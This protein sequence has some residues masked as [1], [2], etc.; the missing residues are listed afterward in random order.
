MNK[1]LF[2][3]LLLVIAIFVVALYYSLSKPIK[4]GL[5]L[6]G[7]AYVV[8]EAVKDQNKNVKIDNDAMNRL[9]EVLNR[10]VNGIGVAESTIQ[11]AGDNRVIIELP[12]LQNTEDA[13]KLIGKTALMEF[14]LMN[15]DGSL[16]ETLLTG[17]ALKKA[18]V[19]YDNLGRPQI[20]FEMTPEGA[21]T[22]A[23]MIGADE[24]FVQCF[25]RMGTENFQYDVNIEGVIKQD[26]DKSLKEGVLLQAL[27]SSKEGPVV[28]VIDE[29][30]KA[31]P[32][33]DSFLLDF[34]ENGRLTTG[35]DTYTKGE[36]SIYTF[37]TSNDKR[38]IDDALLNRSK[39]VEVPRP[40]KELFLEILGLPKNHYLGYVYDKCP[41]FSIRQARQ[42]LE[43]LEVLGEKIDE[44]ALSQYINLGELEINTL[45]DLQKMREID[46]ENF[47]VHINDLQKCKIEIRTD[48][49][50]SDAEAW[51]NFLSKHSKEYEFISEEEEN[52]GELERKLYVVVPTLEKLK[53]LREEGVDFTGY[54][55]WF[56]FEKE[57]EK[58]TDEDIV[59][60]GNVED[61][62]G[63]KFGLVK[64]GLFKV[65]EKDEKTYIFLDSDTR[66]EIEK[67]ERCQ[68]NKEDIER[69]DQ[70][71]ETAE[72]YE[73][74][75][76]YEKDEKERE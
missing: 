62:Q 59:W 76:D 48:L 10:R 4:L 17:S 71:E 22:F 13:I 12:G 24:K 49:Y 15:D 6:K 18:D 56:E 11:K 42:Y 70:I 31:R 26:P 54:A 55:G 35:T 38:E 28:L 7:G 25:P 23:K 39:R 67:Y 1:N 75:E 47:E 69:E 30:D 27:N 51:N 19:S 37:I 40:E 46:D 50:E 66:S 32:E 74:D 34:L 60:A 41:D 64:N 2:L 16:G 53:L 44:Q 61:K 52:Y 5:D 45:D 33:V 9:I 14:K 65:V 73:V 43:D 3:R 68:Q 63:T 72:E 20:S 29:L 8:L 21:E 36:H 57:K 58:I